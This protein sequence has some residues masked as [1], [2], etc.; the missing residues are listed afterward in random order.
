MVNT[1]FLLGRKGFNQTEGAPPC[2]AEL[3]KC[4]DEIKTIMAEVM[5]IV[6]SAEKED[7]PKPAPVAPAP[8][9]VVKQ[10]K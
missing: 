3:R 2:I 4:E 9:P 1:L 10:K 5:T 6:N 7:E 8:A